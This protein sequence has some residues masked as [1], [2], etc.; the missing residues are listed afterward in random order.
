MNI[1]L[2]RSIIV[3]FFIPFFLFDCGGGG[4]GPTNIENREYPEG[5]IEEFIWET[6]GGDILF[7]ITRVANE[8][9]ISVERYEFQTVDVVIMLRDT[10]LEVYELVEDIF[11]EI[12]N[13]YDYTFTQQGPI[14][15]WTTITL[16]FSGNQEL[17]IENIRAWDGEL[18]ILYDFVQENTEPAL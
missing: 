8:F 9:E 2:Y 12:I 16:I 6:K 7:S 11:N 18:R 4:D 3:F 5:D 14:G 10:D 1:S 17:E 15:T 13:M